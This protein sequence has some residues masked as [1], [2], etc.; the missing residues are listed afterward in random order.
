MS[1]GDTLAPVSQPD[2]S[3][4]PRRRQAADR[5][6]KTTARIAAL[7]GAVLLAVLVMSF[8][9]SREGISELQRARQRVSD[10]QKRIEALEAENARLETEIRSLQES[11]FAMERIAREDLGMA[12]EGEV[13]YM[14]PKEEATEEENA[15]NERGSVP[16]ASPPD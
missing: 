15:G 1:G 3:E 2:L 13:V 16:A 6:Q 4:P 8:L 7:V 5:H 14:L 9:I 10:L 11:N 12:R